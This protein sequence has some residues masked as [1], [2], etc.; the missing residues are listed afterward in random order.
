MIKDVKTIISV[1]NLISYF[2]IETIGK[3]ATAT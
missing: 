3:L 1:G 2:G